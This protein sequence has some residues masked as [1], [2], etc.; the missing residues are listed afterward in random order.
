MT[1]ENN[2]KADPKFSKAG[3]MPCRSWSL[4]ARDT[5][6]GSID[7]KTK[8]LVPACQGCYAV[9]GNYRFS[10]V[11]KPRVHNREDWRQADWVDAMV[12]AMQKDTYFRW[13]DSGDVYH[14]ALAK[15]MLEVIQ[16]T[17]HIQHW[18]PTRSHKIPRIRVILEQ[19]NALPNCKVRYS[20]DD[21]RG[22]FVDGVD[23]STIIGDD[24]IP[25]MQDRND[26][27]ICEAYTREGKCADCRVCWSDVPV[28]AYVQHGVSMKKVNRNLIASA[29]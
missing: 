10:N 8:E 17:P 14:P 19:M 21:I 13:F 1:T 7:Q 4:I 29:A 28:V 26:V 15:K 2:M 9:N 6:P 11:R 12:D 22:N 20:G 25:E 16:R 24:Q 18:I 3:K 5:C 23:G 27:A